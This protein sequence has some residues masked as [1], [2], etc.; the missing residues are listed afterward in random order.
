MRV[1]NKKLD[2]IPVGA[3]YIGRPSDWGNPFTHLGYGTARW[4]VSTREQAVHAYGDWLRQQP[5][6]VERARREL[7]GKDLVCWCSPLACHGDVLM[8]VANK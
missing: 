3:V 2:V 4:R 5:L 6:L 7:R 8:E 1:L